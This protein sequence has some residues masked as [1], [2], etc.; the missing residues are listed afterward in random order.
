M[1][2]LGEILE[3][4]FWVEGWKRE[5]ILRAEVVKQRWWRL[6]EYA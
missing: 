1:A 2:S 6:G 5:L 3:V 4:R